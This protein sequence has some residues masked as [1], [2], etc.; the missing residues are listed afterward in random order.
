MG[1]MKV[2]ENCGDELKRLDGIYDL[3]FGFVC[4]HCYEKIRKVFDSEDCH[5]PKCKDCEKELTNLNNDYC[6]KCLFKEMEDVTCVIVQNV[7]L[8]HGV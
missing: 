3:D 6:P 7:D 1:E 8:M 4:F 2:C 5:Y